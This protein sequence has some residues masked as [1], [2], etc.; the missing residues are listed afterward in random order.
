MDID[1]QLGHWLNYYYLWVDHG[2]FENSERWYILPEKALFYTKD[3]GKRGLPLYFYQNK[4]YDDFYAVP[5]KCKADRYFRVI[6]NDFLIKPPFQLRKM[7]HIIHKFEKFNSKFLKELQTSTQSTYDGLYVME[8]EEK[9]LFNY[10]I[11]IILKNK[12]QPSKHFCRSKQNKFYYETSYP[13]ASLVNMMEK[14]HWSNKEK[15]DIAQLIYAIILQ[16]HHEENN[17]YIE[18]AQLYWNM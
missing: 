11:H 3:S 17:T 6:V 10:V 2:S 9:E 13:V 8:Q 18:I 14:L 1:N 4:K 5:S 7:G 12:Y 15:K 16:E